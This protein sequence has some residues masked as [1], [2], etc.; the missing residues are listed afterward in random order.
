MSEQA[1][2]FGRTNA[3]VG[4]VN[5]PA[6][7]ER[8]GKPPAFLFL[9]AGFLHHAGPNRLYVTLARK[10]AALGFSG[11]RFDF[12]GI[13]DSPLRADHVPFQECAV[14]EVREAMDW[15]SETR[16]AE[17]FVLL[18]LCSGGTFALQAAA[19]D[20]RVVGL[21]LINFQGGVDQGAKSYV[22]Q[23]SET[24]YFWR[25]SV[26]NASSWRRALTGKADYRS[27]LRRIGSKV[28]GVLGPR[29]KRPPEVEADE[30]RIEGLLKRGVRL[31][32]IYSVGDPGLDYLGEVLGGAPSEK[33]T[34]ARI[35][36]TTV[37]RADHTFT[38]P[39]G[40]QRVLQTIVDWTMGLASA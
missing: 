25:V 36:L 22:A 11:L 19:L 27:V 13:G 6:P 18:G 3:L 35:G 38:F 15:L 16:S 24:R 9:N 1:V 14:D 33:T 23:R 40:Q 29:R 7:A 30:A 2:V 32:T 21:V 39:D 5:D 31:L 37:P 26:F 28:A 12:S 34:A 20:P 10:I 4:V 8:P 17:R